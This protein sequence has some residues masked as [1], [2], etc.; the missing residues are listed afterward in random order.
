MRQLYFGPRANLPAKIRCVVELCM[1]YTLSVCAT[2]AC[3][4]AFADTE[5]NTGSWKVSF[6]D[7]GARLTLSHKEGN[8][9]LFGCL[10]FTGP[11][12]VT[13]AGMGA[14]GSTARW[15]VVSSRDGFPNRLALVD[16]R[17]RERL[18]HVPAGRRGRFAARLPPH[19][20]RI[21]WDARVSRRSPLPRRCVSL[22]RHAEEGR[23][24]SVRKERPGRLAGRRCA[25]L[26]FCGRSACAQGDEVETGKRKV[27]GVGGVADRRCDAERVF[28]QDRQG[29]VQV[30]LGAE[31]A[32]ARS[33]AFAPCAHRLAQLEHLLRPGRL[34]GE[35]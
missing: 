7:E 16:A 26:S 15:R 27:V 2:F 1:K 17:Q 31:L 22:L 19:G 14:D 4:A 28:A 9:E 10:S 30:A 20:V 23:P 11:A 6:A 25:L 12:K 21:R 13:G 29:L 35:S 33:P 24:R 3:L 8:A 34:E 5:F 32:R 18:H